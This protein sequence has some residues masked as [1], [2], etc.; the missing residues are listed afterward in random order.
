MEQKAVRND[1]LLKHPDGPIVVFGS[2]DFSINWRALLFASLLECRVGIAVDGE[3]LMEE[4]VKTVKALGY[5]TY[6][7][8]DKPWEENRIHLS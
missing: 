4:V 7:W 3:Q 8:K 2:T 1:R 6:R 5:Y